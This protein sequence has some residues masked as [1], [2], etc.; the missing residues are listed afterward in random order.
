MQHIKILLAVLPFP[1]I[2]T[3]IL[4]FANPGVITKENVDAYLELY[5]YDYVLYSPKECTT[6]K[7]PVVPRSRFDRYTNRRIAY[8]FYYKSAKL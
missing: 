7:I 6:L 1:W 5:P 4:H 3:A 2:F 8:V